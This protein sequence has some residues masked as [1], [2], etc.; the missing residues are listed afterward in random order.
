MGCDLHHGIGTPVIRAF[1]SALTHDSLP[2]HNEVQ[3]GGDSSS[4]TSKEHILV[5]GGRAMVLNVG[6]R[7]F[8]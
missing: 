4:T 6:K 8:S 2:S 1:I 7:L 3:L 5:R